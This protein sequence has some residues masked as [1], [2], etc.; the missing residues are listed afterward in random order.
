MGE[1][2]TNG[3]GGLNAVD[4]ELE[5]IAESARGRKKRGGGR[6]GGAPE[7]GLL[8]FYDS[9]RG[10]IAEAVERR[11]GALGQQA[12]EA[13]L[14]VP[15][16]FILLVRLLLDREVPSSTKALIGGALAYFVMPF[17]LFPEAMVGAGGFVEDLVLAVVVLAHVFDPAMEARADRYWSGSKRLKVVLADVAGAAESLLG[18]DLWARVKATLARRGIDVPDA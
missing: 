17:D 10:R 4:S 9:L 18:T 16:I 1:D 2:K 3:S 5:E 6:S 12:V 7:A 14:L 15:D 13:L 11:A 8:S